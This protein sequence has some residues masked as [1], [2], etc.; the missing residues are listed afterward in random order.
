MY[1]LEDHERE[2]IIGRFYESELSAVDKK[3]DV[4]RVEKTLKRKRV[5]GKDMVLVKW[6]G[7][8]S[9]HNS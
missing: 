2:P 4:Y 3:D 6:L 5:K 7:Y 9:K 1:E 8:G